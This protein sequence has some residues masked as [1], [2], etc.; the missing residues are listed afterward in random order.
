MIQI[1]RRPEIALQE[2]LEAV[3]SRYDL[4]GTLTP[5][6]G[7]RDQNFLLDTSDGNRYVVKISSPEEPDPIL[8]FETE[9]LVKLCSETEGLVPGVKEAQSGEHLV[10]FDDSAGNT[11]RLRIVDFLPGTLL[12]NA[13]PRTDA[14][15]YDFG[16]RVAELD[17]ALGGYPDHPPARFNF[18]WALGSAG[19]VMERCLELFTGERRGLIENAHRSFD[20][21]GHD[22][23]GLGSQI[24]HGDV[25]EHNVLVSDP[26]GTR[27]YVTGFI[28][29]GDA[30]S[31]PRVFDLAIA[32]A[33][34]TLGVSDPI[35][36]AAT[37]VRGFNDTT[38]LLQ[39]EIDVIF[40]LARARLGQSVS[41]AAWRRNQGEAVDPSRHVSEEP[42]WELLRKL[43]DVPDKFLRGV[44][45]DAC[46]LSAN[47]RTPALMEWLDE[48]ECSPV[49][50]V[51]EEDGALTV[52]DLSV[53]SPDLDGRD[54]DDTERFATRIARLIEDAGARIGIGR[55]LEPR[56]FYLTD[57]FAGREGDPRERR[58]IHLGLDLFVEAGTDVRAPLDGKV[59]VIETNAARLDYGP[60]VVLEHLSPH[61]RFW[62]L[63]GHLE[64]TSVDELEIDQQLQAGETFARIGAPPE[65]GDWPPHLHL[66]LVTHFLGHGGDFP[67]VALPRERTVWASFSPDPNSLLGLPVETT[68]LE[69]DKDLL[70]RRGKALPANLSL[71]YA[72]PIHV[73]RARGTR[74]YDPLGRSYLDCVNNVAH[75]GHEH[76][77]VVRAGRRQMAVLNT[78]TRYLHR[79]VIEYA[80]RLAELLPEP[81]SRCFF[82]NSG[83]EANELALRMARSHSNGS[84]VV[85][86]E[87][88]YHGHTQTLVDVSHYKFAGKGGRG[89]P[90]W[91]RTTPA[92]DVYRGAYGRNMPDRASRY[93][94]HVRDALADLRGASITPA[95]FIAE[96]FL[97][98]GGQIE[99]P[100][101]YLAA[102][103]QHARAA[104]AV[105]IADEI[106]T[107]FGRIGSDFWS[108]ESQD[109]V[110]DIVTLGK[111]VGN[112]HPIGVVITTPEIAE[113]FDNGM[114]F[115]STFGGNPVSA[116]IGLAVLD[117]LEE[118][119]LQDRAAVL[120]GTLK[121]SLAS[122]AMRHDVVG[123]IRGRGLFLGIDLVS[124]RASKR[125]APEVARYVIDRLAERGVL[126]GVDGPEHNVLKI[127]PPMPFSEEDAERLV[128]ELDTVLGEDAVQWLA[129]HAEA[130]DE[131]SDAV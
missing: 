12:A 124:D 105:C 24:I 82:V 101:G 116:A 97:S 22:F 52:L 48:Q 51:P 36:A 121:G 34:A 126:V 42:A 3:R 67:G 15:F 46:G 102:A 4:D 54:T 45:R 61:G 68:Y 70:E 111:P 57:Q 20:E 21:R 26:D 93:A 32:V 115:F 100:Q 53:D 88:G 43:D 89:A 18:D 30:H 59:R 44:L 62:T 95:A 60:T 16:K 38:P 37:I 109:V 7:E 96:T 80:E 56:G 118:E 27:R 107:G 74:L 58:T 41:I 86:L 6:P 49:I 91:V 31:A 112:G 120:G 117:V 114:E 85:A 99:P 1:Q 81:L 28:D 19:S 76:P 2:V 127:K 11:Q 10:E 77:S 122:L 129:D 79:N 25:N 90:P 123:D 8:R 131:G 75:V 64:Q 106:Q 14:L 83:S 92:P 63:Y 110:P 128:E 94:G 98:C 39:S 66:Q 104:G 40:T 33:Y 65:N 119:D 50:D 87:G 72:S 71:S 73:V 69:E 125:P 29:F 130:A 9:M 17:S 5:L 55:Y 113:S 13:R 78:N 103:Y 23:L 47:V 84:G 35:S 108:F